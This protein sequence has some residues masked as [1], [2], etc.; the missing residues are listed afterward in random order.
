MM[1]FLHCVCACS[2]TKSCL[3]L[4]NSMDCSPLGSPVC[5]I[6]QAR[7]LVWAAMPP[8]WNLA[9]SGI[10]LVSL[11]SPA[12]AGGFFTTEPPGKPHIY[13]QL[14]SVQSLSRVRLFETP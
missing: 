9:D 10:K 5:E 2:V 6:F 8:P 14:S 1:T 3:T 12:L 13:V 7:I 4:C 11:M